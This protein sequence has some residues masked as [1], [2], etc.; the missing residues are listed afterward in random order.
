MP[1]PQ[2]L[3]ATHFSCTMPDSLLPGF[4]FGAR[5][6]TYSFLIFCPTPPFFFP[7]VFPRIVFLFFF[8]P[9]T[10]T[11][12]LDPLA[13][14]L[15]CFLFFCLPFSSTSPG[16]PSCC[17]RFSKTSPPPGPFDCA[18]TWV[19]SLFAAPPGF[20]RT[21]VPKLRAGPLS[22]LPLLTN[23]PVFFPF[24]SNHVFLVPSSFP[25]SFCFTT[26]FFPSLLVCV[27][28]HFLFSCR[29]DKPISSGPSP[30]KIPLNSLAPAFTITFFLFFSSMFSYFGHPATEFWS[31]MGGEVQ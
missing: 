1:P 24:V 9:Q 5:V 26:V 12:F 2:Q 4:F 15:S 30:F 31:T 28:V 16:P 7:A 27:G 29:P 6:T 20:Q 13:S 19:F 10:P 23:D 18:G 21:F 25:S 8:G 17:C 22:P 11:C 14:A 3:Q